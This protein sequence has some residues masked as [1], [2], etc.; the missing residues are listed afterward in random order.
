MMIRLKP[1]A[2]ILVTGVLLGASGWRQQSAAQTNPPAE[3]PYQFRSRDPFVEPQPGVRLKPRNL[4]LPPSVV[5]EEDGRVTFQLRA[6]EAQRVGINFSTEGYVVL[7]MTKGEDGVWRRTFGPLK[8]GTYNYT[9]EVDGVWIPDPASSQQVIGHQSIKYTLLEI[10]GPGTD[11]WEFRDVPHGA[12][13]VFYYRSPLL[14]GTLRRCRVY[15]PPGYDRESGRSYPVLLLLHGSGGSDGLW[16]DYVRLHWVADNLIA[17]GKIEPM[18]IVMPNGT[19]GDVIDPFPRSAVFPPYVPEDRLFLGL[20]DW[21]MRVAVGSFATELLPA[22]RRDFRVKPG[23]DHCGVTGLSM[24]GGQSIHAGMVYPEVFGY[25]APVAPGYGP[26]HLHS[27]KL[28]DRIWADHKC[29]VNPPA[30]RIVASRNDEYLENVKKLFLPAMQKAGIP[31]PLIL[32]EG[33]HDYTTARQQLT[34]HVLPWLFRP[35]STG[36]TEGVRGSTGAASRM[37]E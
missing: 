34:E 31:C 12:L 35:A 4:N 5:Y 37:L 2:A 33:A 36:A 16:T 14:G 10:S 29:A 25:V 1:I 6:P 21:N 28:Y 19:V 32:T 27:R 23:R 20:P 30:W 7:D 24:G 17:T 9:F 22:I 8:P 18:I 13:R 15:T 3:K 11:L 26:D